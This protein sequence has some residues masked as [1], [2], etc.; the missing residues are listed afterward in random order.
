MS[1]HESKL[2]T[3]LKR[4]EL[5]TRKVINTRGYNSDVKSLKAIEE[6]IREQLTHANTRNSTRPIR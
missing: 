5:S 2:K 3:A 1:G 4:L 6:M